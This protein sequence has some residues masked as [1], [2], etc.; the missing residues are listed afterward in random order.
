VTI[1]IPDEPVDWRAKG[2]WVPDGT[3]SAAARPGLFD[4]GFTWPLLTLRRSA[5]EANIATIAAYCARHGLDYAPHA[6]TTMAPGLIAAQLDAGAWGMTV[7]TPNQ[8]LVLRRLGVP[9][10]FIANEVL[11]P[12]AL[13]WLAEEGTRG[14]EVYFQVDSIAGV[15]AAASALDRTQ[16]LLRV[17]V[18]LGHL[19]G[20]TGSRTLNDL[21][22][23]ARSAAAVERLELVGVTGYE[24]QLEDQAAVDGFLDHIA[25]GVKSLSAAGLLPDPPLVSAGGSVWFDRVAA[26]LV[27]GD[28]GRV[29]LR[30]GAS[31]THDDGYYREKTPFHRIPQEGPLTAALDLWAQVISTPE[32]GLAIVGMGKRDA[33]FDEGLPVI[34]DVRRGGVLQPISGLTVTKL[35]DQ[36]TYVEVE[37][38]VEVEVGDLLR[39][40][41]SHPCTAFDK[42]R[43]IPVVDDEHRVVDVLHTYF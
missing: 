16:G 23:V 33:P 17:F 29:I 30:S 36:H 20:R 37:V 13:R 4:G 6:K 12:T 1:D 24:G 38:D 2:F 8:A 11:D 31:V 18:E 19:G 5:V 27:P 9:R 25:D 28:L 14:W 34:F 26:K 43:H 10:V 7:A 41:I 15:E 35:N 32:P 40:G 3:W 21:E 22:I 39:F 42:W